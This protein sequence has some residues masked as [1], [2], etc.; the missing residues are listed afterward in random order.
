MLDEQEE[1]T[2]VYPLLLYRHLLVFETGAARL[3]TQ[4]ARFT[5]VHSLS[6]MDRIKLAFVTI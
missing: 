6:R 2:V 1:L 4:P 3:L 5:T